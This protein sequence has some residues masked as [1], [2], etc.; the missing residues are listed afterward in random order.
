[1]IKMGYS[2]CT[3]VLYKVRNA[4]GDDVENVGRLNMVKRRL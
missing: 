3:F 1:M 2:R 4:L